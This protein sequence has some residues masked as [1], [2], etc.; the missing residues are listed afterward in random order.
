MAFDVNRWMK[1]ARAR[2]NTAVSQGN[3]SLD[4]LEAERDAELADK[5]WLR[6]D[7]AA[8]TLDEAR[9]RIEWEAERQRKAQ[10][11]HAA[12]AAAAAAPTNTGPV[13]PSMPPGSDHAKGSPSVPHSEASA[14]QTGARLELEAQQR[15]SADRLDQIRAELGV[16]K[17]PPSEPGP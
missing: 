11:E 7:G 3:R 8:P 9:D 10:A 16:A 1:Y 12:A 2:L 15:A 13:T 14:E 5:P 4:R 6:S 17:P